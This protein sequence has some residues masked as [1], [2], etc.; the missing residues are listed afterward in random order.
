MTTPSALPVPK[1]PRMTDKA[2]P[3]SFGSASDLVEVTLLPY[4]PHVEK[5]GW[6][7]VAVLPYSLEPLLARENVPKRHLKDKDNAGLEYVKKVMGCRMS[8]YSLELKNDERGY[9]TNE[10]PCLYQSSTETRCVPLS[11]VIC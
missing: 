5:C 10:V 6:E 1:K 3:P 11:K 4:F 7:K 8:M 9:Q 2:E